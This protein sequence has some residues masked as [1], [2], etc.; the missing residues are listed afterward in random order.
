MSLTSIFNSPSNLTDFTGKNPW[1]GVDKDLNAISDLSSIIQ[2][3][4][5]AEKILSIPGHGFLPVRSV[6]L[7]GE[8]KIDVSDT[9][10]FNRFLTTEELGV[11][12]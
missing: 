1:P 12:T 4:L 5:F 2:K 8:L 9:I 11:K 3:L 10:D 6:R 7:E